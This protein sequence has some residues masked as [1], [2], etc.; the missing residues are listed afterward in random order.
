[1]ANKYHVNPETGRVNI[2]RASKKLCDFAVDGVEPKHYDN[3][4]DAKIGAE[5]MLSNEYG[6]SFEKVSKKSRQEEDYK[7]GAEDGL[8]GGLDPDALLSNSYVHDEW[9]RGYV[10]ALQK[11]SDEKSK[12]SFDY[13]PY[14]FVCKR[15]TDHIGEHEALVSAGMAEYD[16]ET[17]YVKRTKQY[18]EKEV[19]RVHQRESEKLANGNTVDY[20]AI[21]NS[22]SPVK[23]EDSKKVLIGSEYGID[24][25]IDALKN[26]SNTDE[27]KNIMKEMGYKNPED[28]MTHKV[29]NGSYPI[30]VRSATK[31]IE[32]NKNA[33][34]KEYIRQ[35]EE[36]AYEE[37]MNN[38]SRGYSDTP[39]Y[40]SSS[41]NYDSDVKL[42]N[43]DE[44]LSGDFQFDEDEDNFNSDN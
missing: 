18:S 9:D 30:A 14:C 29:I 15:P 27:Y 20:E 1:M 12:S 4:A 17:G 23:T 39:V 5:N 41:S 8:R 42:L 28:S 37:E 13:G 44:I 24:E 2:C 7:D 32:S 36:D 40:S 33:G 21:M 19:E 43:D 3:K 35:L 10:E 25:K 11:A 34:T 26:F 38:V 22:T 6:G 31:K 16:D